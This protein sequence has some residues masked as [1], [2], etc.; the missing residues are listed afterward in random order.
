MITDNI[1]NIQLDSKCTV[2]IEDKNNTNLNSKQN[3]LMLSLSMF[4]NTSDNISSMLE[5][6]QGESCISLRV[7]DWFVT[8]YAKKNNIIYDIIINNKIKRFNVYLDYKAQLN[9]YS[10]KLFDPFCRRD[11]IE[12]EFKD[13]IPSIETT[14]GQLNFFRWCIENNILRYIK[15]NLEHIEYDMNTS[16]RNQYTKKECI[17]PGKRKKRH[18]LSIS[19]TK[20]INK[21]NV[22]I[23][24]MFE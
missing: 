20:T 7:I 13:N 22:K 9:A 5:I 23:T 3:L 1:L 19:A 2:D 16:I 17:E 18:E 4:F 10:K 11:R 14:V 21:H 24:V 15:N 12:F 6:V 8:N